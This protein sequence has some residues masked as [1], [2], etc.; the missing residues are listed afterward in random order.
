MKSLQGDLILQVTNSD[1]PKY[2]I[3]TPTKMQYVVE[4][5]SSNS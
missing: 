2:P 1:Q 3:S 4:S 5:E